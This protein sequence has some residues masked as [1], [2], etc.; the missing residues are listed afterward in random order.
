M[1]RRGDKM[2]W[3]STYIIT[4]QYLDVLSQKGL[5][6]TLFVQTDDYTAY[7][8]VCNNT[9]A[10]INV[11]TTCPVTKRG[12]FVYQYQPSNGSSTSELN[13]SY[14]LQLSTIEQKC[15]NMYSPYEMKEHVEEMLVGLQL[16]MDSRYLSTDFQ[17][18]VT[19]FLVCCHHYPQYV[20]AI[21][22]TLP[23]YDVKLKCPAHGFIRM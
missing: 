2:Y 15:V 18:N 10:S 1:I 7:E 3:E 21:N 4:K 8:E 9:D 13:H 14:L 12:A 23:P 6:T 22:S 17:S 19:R 16:C 5:S 11:I 20:F